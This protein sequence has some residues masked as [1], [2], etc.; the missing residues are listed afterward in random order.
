MPGAMAPFGVLP[1]PMKSSF[2]LNQ[3]APALLSLVS[4]LYAVLRL[5]PER[6]SVRFAGRCAES[7][8]FMP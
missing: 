7:Q 2:W 1:P 6:D 5:P 4:Q 8:K 3:S